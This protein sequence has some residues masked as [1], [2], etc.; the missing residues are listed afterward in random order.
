MLKTI[1]N[2]YTRNEVIVL[3][4]RYR[5]IYASKSLKYENLNTFIKNEL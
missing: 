1:K 4:N 3:L 5:V 2:N